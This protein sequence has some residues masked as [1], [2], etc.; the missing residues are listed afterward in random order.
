MI[1]I[2][3]KVCVITGGGK[4]GKVL[5]LGLHEAG[6]KVIIGESDIS[7]ICD[8]K[9]EFIEKFIDIEVENLDIS[10][11]TSVIN[12]IV[13]LKKTFNRVDAW[14]NT[15]FPKHPDWGKNNIC[16]RGMFNWNVER[17]LWGYYDTSSKIANL[18]MKDQGFG[19]VI[20]FG[21]IYGVNAPDFSIYEKTSIKMPI[22]YAMIKGAINMMSK[23]LASYYGKHGIRFNVISPGGIFENQDSRFIEN[24]QKKTVLG[25]MASEDDIVGLVMFLISDASSYITGQNILID[26]GFTIK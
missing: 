22:V 17:H 12:F 6:A 21:S 20:N 1:D 10:N 8:L 9:K 14:I 5:A 13:Y 4:I 3:N 11:E 26:G 23:Y 19:S 25:R 24:Y 15:A 16:S 7:K 18:M 2:K